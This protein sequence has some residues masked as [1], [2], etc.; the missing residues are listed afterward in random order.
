MR[1]DKFLSNN[2]HFSRSEIKIALRRSNIT[3]N[4]AIVRSG[5]GKI[6]PESDEVLING[7]VVRNFEKVYLVIN[8]PSGIISASADKTR[9]TVVDLV[10]DEYKHLDLFPVGRLDRDTTGLLIITNDG[11]FAHKVISPNNCVEKC[12]RVVLDDEIP[13]NA[14]EIFKNGITLADGTKCRPAKLEIINKTVADVTITEG[15]YHQ[16]KRMFGVIGLG[17]VKLHRLSIGKL[18]LPSTLKEGE[19]IELKGNE[20]YEE[21]LKL[22]VS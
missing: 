7:N 3:V 18:E 6:D 13:E 4:G 17:V 14:V 9:K 5:D 2:T 1:L 15:K 10:P 22:T 19:C 12:Y 16:V 8:K 21:T 11:E 20:I